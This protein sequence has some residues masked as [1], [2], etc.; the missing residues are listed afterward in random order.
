MIEQ[1]VDPNDSRLRAYS[2]L[3]DVQLRG[4]REVAEGIFVAEGEKVI[5]RAAAAGFE[6]RSFLLAE[7]WLD[8]LRDV[9]TSTGA[10]AYVAQDHVVESITGY[11]VHRGALAIFC[12]RAATPVGEILAGATKII[13]L[14]D[15]VDHT[16]V[17]LIFRSA[18]ALGLDAV[19]LAPRCADPLYRRAIKTSM[20]ATLTLPYARLDDWYHG[21]ATIR[22][23]GF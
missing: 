8:G 23:A 10:P 13:V 16:N 3:T 12:R 4:S 2:G 22:D 21:V 9:I 11:R 19:V 20:G 15:L 6:A 5:R 7:R 1:V 18:A 14:E 17:G